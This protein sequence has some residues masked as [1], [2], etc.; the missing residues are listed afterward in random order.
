MRSLFAKCLITLFVVLSLGTGLA[1]ASTSSR[2]GMF[3]YPLKKTTQRAA[4]VLKNIPAVEIH[5]A[6]ATP[7]PV[8]ADADQPGDPTPEPTSTTMAT[9]TS[10]ATVTREPTP[11]KA[12][13]MI[14]PMATAS[15]DPAVASTNTIT[16]SLDP[17]A[18]TLS[19]ENLAGSID[20][21]LQR[22]DRSSHDD[23][24][25]SQKSSD[26]SEKNEAEE[27]SSGESS[28]EHD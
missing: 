10:T 11:A 16:P 28:S 2:P 5:L 20:Q 14:T 4:Q 6:A 13:D 22:Q 12:A 19:V 18:Q 27:H 8:A 23:S 9:A 25:K 17:P 15:A 7:L 21:S 1:W 24:S 3:L 26:A